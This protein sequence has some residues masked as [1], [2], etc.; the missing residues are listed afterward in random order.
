M[1]ALQESSSPKHHESLGRRLS[2]RWLVVLMFAFAVLL[3]GAM[4]LYWHFYTLPF[5]DL[6]NAIN[7]EFPESSPRAIGGR[8]KG[9][10]EEPETLRVVVHCKFDPT[11]D[12][13]RA[14]AMAL[15]LFETAKENVSIN[16]YEI[17]EVY[18]CHRQPEQETPTWLRRRTVS[19]WESELVP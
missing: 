18:L 2:G 5:R 16:D 14:D 3:T 13:A 12:E 17:F 7:A 10:E 15:R 11:L 9:R 4:A 19:E 6:Q 1:S 8:W